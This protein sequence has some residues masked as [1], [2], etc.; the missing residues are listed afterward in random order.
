MIAEAARALVEDV[1]ASLSAAMR[2]GDDA[3]LAAA[4]DR[5]DALPPGSLLR[6]PNDRCG[7]SVAAR[8]RSAHARECAHRPARCPRLG[9]GRRMAES[10][11]AAHARDASSG[12]C[13]AA[14]ALD[15]LRSW[16]NGVSQKH[17]AA[18]E[19]L[20]DDGYGAAGSLLHLTKTE[21][22]KYY[23][24][25]PAGALW[26]RLEQ[27]RAGTASVQPV[28]VRALLD[29]ALRASPALYD[30]ATLLDADDV[31]CLEGLEPDEKEA[32]LRHAAPEGLRRQLLAVFMPPSPPPPPRGAG[33]A[34]PL[35]HATVAG[36]YSF[37]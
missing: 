20:Y 7:A 11:L 33:A 15:T 35:A 25:A 8:D 5:A 29:L 4:A 10:A 37:G 18:A 6:C 22:A 12:G 1:Q 2:A 27:V 31:D 19:Q 28:D 13:T 17:A 3:A 26:R 21:L 9:C 16:L 23:N 14:E 24:V 36:V 34:S 30:A 32:L